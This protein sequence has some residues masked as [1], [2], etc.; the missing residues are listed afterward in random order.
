VGG[1]GSDSPE[2]ARVGSFPGVSAAALIAVSGT[3][4]VN[5]RDAPWRR[6]ARRDG[7]ARGRRARFRLGRQPKRQR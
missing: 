5:G 2:A 3:G 4:H 6:G 7:E 1:H